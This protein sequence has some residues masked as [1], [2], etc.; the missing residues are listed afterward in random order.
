MGT[1]RACVSV[2]YNMTLLEST[3]Y[4]IGTVSCPIDMGTSRGYYYKG[5]ISLGTEEVDA[6]DAHWC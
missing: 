3:K 5:D 4:G 2:E 1:Q 6:D